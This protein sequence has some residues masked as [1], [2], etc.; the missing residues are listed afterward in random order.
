SRT[1][2]IG[3]P[4]GLDT[5]SRISRY[6]TAAFR[7]TVQALQFAHGLGVLHLDIHCLNFFLTRDLDLKASASVDGEKSYCSYRYSYR[8]F[9]ADGTDIVAESSVSVDTEIFALGTALY[10]MIAREEP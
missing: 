3:K 6:E 4:T 10:V 8:L 5:Q 9:G 7:T 2:R 1:R